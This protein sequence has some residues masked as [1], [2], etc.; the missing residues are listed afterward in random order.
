MR[1]PLFTFK[2]EAIG[3]VVFPL[4]AAAVAI[5]LIVLLWFWRSIF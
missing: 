3:M 4:A 5:I 1:I 2:N